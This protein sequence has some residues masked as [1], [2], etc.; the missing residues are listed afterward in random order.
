MSDFDFP[1]KKEVTYPEVVLMVRV[2]RALSGCS[3]GAVSCLGPD[4][5]SIPF[6]PLQIGTG[7]GSNATLRTYVEGLVSKGVMIDKGGVMDKVR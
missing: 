1:A 4:S 2:V 5:H 3:F 6:P 7:F